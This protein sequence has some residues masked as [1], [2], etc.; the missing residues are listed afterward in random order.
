[1]LSFPINSQQVVLARFIS[2]GLWSNDGPPSAF[3][4]VGLRA[5][6]LALNTCVR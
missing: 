1:M 4:G 6:Q 2:L 5:G 3:L